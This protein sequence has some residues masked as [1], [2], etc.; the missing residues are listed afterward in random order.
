MVGLLTTSKGETSEIYRMLF[1]VR[2][3]AE[4]LE[5]Q[6]V[7]KA[8]LVMPLRL[9]SLDASRTHGYSVLRTL[10]TSSQV[11]SRSG[12]SVRLIRYV[13]AGSGPTQNAQKSA[14]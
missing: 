14:E 5:E 12:D 10:H 4:S 2:R 9:S 7:T 11:F 3:L 6:D 8:V 13:H 1:L